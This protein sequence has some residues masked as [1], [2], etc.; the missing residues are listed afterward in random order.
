MKGKGFIFMLADDETEVEEAV[1]LT[2]KM[3]G[4]AMKSKITES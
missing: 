1:G 2:E 3:N 4:E